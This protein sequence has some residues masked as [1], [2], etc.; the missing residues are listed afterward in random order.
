MCIQ[1]Y[2]KLNN[3]FRIIHCLIIYTQILGN[4]TI[5][6]FINI[7]NTCITK[8]SC[9]FCYCIPKMMFLL[10]LFTSLYNL[11]Y[12]QQIQIRRKV[13]V[14]KFYLKSVMFKQIILIFYLYSLIMYVICHADFSLSKT[15][16]LSFVSCTLFV[17][18]IFRQTRL[19]LCPHLFIMFIICNAI[20]Q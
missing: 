15:D 6:L 9:C 11:Y 19:M 4:N 14:C 10:L 13:K 16:T 12:M 1:V 17:N 8:L 20:V 3:I 18:A 2:G 5:V 7:L